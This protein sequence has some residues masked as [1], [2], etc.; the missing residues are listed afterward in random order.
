MSNMTSSRPYLFRAIYD[1]ILDNDMTPYVVIA[2][3]DVEIDVPEQYIQNGQVILN[4]SPTAV[5]KFSISAKSLTFG[6]RFN[7]V[8]HHI[9]CPIQNV[10]AVYSNENGRGIAFPDEW[11]QRLDGSDSDASQEVEA[12]SE[13]KPSNVGDKKN[14]PFLRILD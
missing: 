13:Q 2:T 3:D 12:E 8:A 10:L 4:V 7:G 1:W 6:A 5:A 11:D 14:N 9:E